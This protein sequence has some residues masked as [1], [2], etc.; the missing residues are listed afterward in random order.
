MKGRADIHV[1]T[2]YSGFGRLGFLRFPE[3]VAHPCDVV[4]NAQASGLNVVCITDHNSIEGAFKAKEC[5]KSYPG[6]DVVVGE[7]IT[8]LN[9]ELIGLYLT[10]EIPQGLSVEETIDR[11]RS[12]GGIVIAP[13][14]FSLHCPSLGDRVDHLDIDGIE[15]I[16]AGHI[17]GYANRMAQSHE[18]NGK[19][20]V[21]GGSDSHSLNT[22]AYAHTL[23]DGTNAEDLRKAILERRTSAAGKRMP[24]E[25][26]IAWSVGVVLASDVL[27]LKSIFGLIRE[28]DMH[29]PIAT[30]INLM[31]TGKKLIAFFGSLIYLTP[32]VPYLCG[33]TSERFL[34]RLAKLHESLK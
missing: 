26:G 4:K 18:N 34:K 1:H 23:F 28:V 27:I 29:D 13:H 2:R 32:P 17:D 8:T 11:I 19:W 24:L 20:A 9:G 30:K 25:K 6:V 14:P 7:E 5:A 31:G 22:I 12:Q 21:V 3:S 16:N 10:E 15:T 33:I